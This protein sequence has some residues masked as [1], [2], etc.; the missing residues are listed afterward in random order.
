MCSHCG[1]GISGKYLL[2][3][4]EAQRMAARGAVK[5]SVPAVP[6]SVTAVGAG[7]TI[8]SVLAFLS[9]PLGLLFASNA[10]AGV[11]ILAAGAILAVIARINQAGLHHREAMA[12]RAAAQH[13][14]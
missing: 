1:K 12:A 2:A 11:A 9:I 10:T 14:Q 6:V 5:P 7:A 4:Q 3:D 13:E 8:F